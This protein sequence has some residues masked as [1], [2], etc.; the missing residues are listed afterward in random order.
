MKKLLASLSERARK[1]GRNGVTAIIDMGSFFLFGRDGKATELIKYEASFVP[2]TKGGNIRGFRCYHVAN[3]NTLKD[4]QKEEITQ[5]QKKKILEIT[6]SN[7]NN[8]ITKL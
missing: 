7:N 5:G 4:S 8:N 2:K 3:Y 6:S 1:E